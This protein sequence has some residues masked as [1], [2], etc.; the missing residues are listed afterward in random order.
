MWGWIFGLCNILYAVLVSSLV[1]LLSKL[2]IEKWFLSSSLVIPDSIIPDSII[3]CELCRGWWRLVEWA[4]FSLPNSQKKQSKN[5]IR[6]IQERSTLCTIVHTSLW[7][8]GIVSNDQWAWSLST[9]LS[10]NERQFIVVP[11]SHHL[12]IMMIKHIMATGWW[13][14][15]TVISSNDERKELILETEV[16]G[17]S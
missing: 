1:F 4:Q 11:F 8:T 7:S 9:L 6:K 17:V 12:F 10:E 5:F 16:R 13:K 2:Q 3:P 15:R 14:L